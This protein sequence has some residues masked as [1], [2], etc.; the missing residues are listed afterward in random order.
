MSSSIGSDLLLSVNDRTYGQQTNRTY[1]PQTDTSR[2][3]L[4]KHTDRQTPGFDISNMQNTVREKSL[5]L[6]I[7][8]FKG[9]VPS[10]L[11]KVVGVMIKRVGQLGG[12]GV[13]SPIGGPSGFLG[14]VELSAD[15]LNREIA[16]VI[17]GEEKV[18]T[19]PFTARKTDI[20]TIWS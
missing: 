16:G 19:L 1:D 9:P 20:W 13:K 17:T 6:E 4:G 10:V 14:K 7:F 2:S 15:Q 12:F 5:R 3:I 11:G 8:D 18:I